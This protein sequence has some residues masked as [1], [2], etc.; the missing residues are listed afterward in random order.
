MKLVSVNGGP[1]H[2]SNYE[3]SYEARSEIGN[4][5]NAVKEYL[6]DGSTQKLYEMQ[7]TVINGREL[8]TSPD[9]IDFYANQGSLEFEDIYEES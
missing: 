5:W 3:L 8:E 9:V 4:Y 7:G 6:T 1:E 2:I